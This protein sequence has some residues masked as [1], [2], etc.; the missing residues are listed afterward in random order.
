[1][2]D[3]SVFEVTAAT[4]QVA[5]VERSMQTPVLLDFWAEWCGPCQTLGPVLEQLATAYGGAFALGKVDTEREQ[6]LAYAFQVQGIP[7]CVLVD[8]G[9]PVDA[10]QGALREAEV[11]RFLARNNI[12]PVTAEKAPE[13]PVDPDSP[14]ARLARARNAL[15]AADPAATKAALAGF[16]EEDPAFDQA[17]RIL[18][19][20]SWFETELR[21][22][23]PG[24]E[25]HLAAARAA[26]GKQQY[27]AAMGE[28][29]AAAEADKTFRG[30][31]PRKAMLLCFAVLGED[32]ERVDEYRRRLATLLY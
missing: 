14:A 24:A 15:A 17:T 25:G 12:Q 16:P 8:N 18:D 5:V 26:F 23:A 27:P 2:T 9:K 6:D 13:V 11:R 20:L 7:F 10:F 1:M 21:A 3:D 19:G 32:D 30:G 22:E 28:L 29:L 31:L 4:F